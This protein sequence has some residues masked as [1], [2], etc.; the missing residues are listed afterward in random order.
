MTTPLDHLLLV[1]V[2]CEIVGVA[3][4]MRLAGEN[5]DPEKKAKVG[6]Y[7]RLHAWPLWLPREYLDARG[8]AYASARDIATVC[9]LITVAAFILLRW[10]GVA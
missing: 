2:A 6:I 5:V 9:L 8:R 1:F 10:I 3:V 7:I 4:F